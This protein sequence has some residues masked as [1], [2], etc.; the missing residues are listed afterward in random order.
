[1][2]MKEA[3]DKDVIGEDD[4]AKDLKVKPKPKG[5]TF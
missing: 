5:K 4:E 1:M 3:E 2:K